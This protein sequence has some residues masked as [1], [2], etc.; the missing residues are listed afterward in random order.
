[1]NL[2]PKKFQGIQILILILSAIWIAGTTYFTRPPELGKSPSPREGFPA[3]VFTLNTIEGNSVNLE[4]FR[5]KVVLLNFWA[6]WCPPCKAEMPAFEALHQAYRGQD[7]V[8]LAVNTTFQDDLEAAQQFVDNNH[9][10]FQ[11]LFDTDGKTSNTYQ[12]L[13]M[14]SSYFIDREGIIRKVIIGGPMS[15]ALIQ[16]QVRQL[17]GEVR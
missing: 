8:I 10:T 1:M 9:L 12:V 6:S 7:F 17:L 5:G 14:P 3:P 11:I 4:D 16:T 13:A 2:S 15:E